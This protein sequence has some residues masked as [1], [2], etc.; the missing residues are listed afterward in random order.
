MIAR[1]QS[2]SVAR[3]TAVRL[4]KVLAKGIDGI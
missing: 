1:M 4:F 2:F 3:T